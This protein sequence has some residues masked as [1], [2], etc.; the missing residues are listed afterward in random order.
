MIMGPCCPLPNFGAIKMWPEAWACACVV[1]VTAGG[2]RSGRERKAHIPFEGPDEAFGA[3]FTFGVKDPPFG[4]LAFGVL[5][6][7]MRSRGSQPTAFVKARYVRPALTVARNRR[8]V[9]LVP[10]A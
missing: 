1:T 3:G 5:A 10:I 2:R 4:G 9:N 6:F 8:R 7:G